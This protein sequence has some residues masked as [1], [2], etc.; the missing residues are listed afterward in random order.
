MKNRTIV[1]AALAASF[2]SLTACTQKLKLEAAYDSPAEISA[3][4]TEAGV[5]N[6]ADVN[7]KVLK[8]FHR[9]YGELADAKWLRSAN[10]FM[11]TFRNNN[12]N[13]T[14]YYRNNG[15]VDAAVHY[16]DAGQLV[17]P[18]KAMVAA[19][20]PNHVVS[21]VVEVQKAGTTAYYVKA[22]DATTIKTIKVVGEEWE[23]VETL[24]KR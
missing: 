17:A 11:V 12:M 24:V 6:T 5:L 7:P 21:T 16:Y 9:V 2:F 13:N 10:G 22:Q 18:V 8:S 19:A 14:V 4:T 20:L 1:Y 3:Y 23:L 15:A